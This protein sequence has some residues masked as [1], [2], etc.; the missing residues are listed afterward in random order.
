MKMLVDKV[1][2][3][4]TG[5]NYVFENAQS[6]KDLGVTIINNN[7]WSAEITNRLFKVEKAFFALNKMYKVLIILE[8]N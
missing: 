7:D 8:I 5:S 4:L 3:N 6:L 1:E 2:R